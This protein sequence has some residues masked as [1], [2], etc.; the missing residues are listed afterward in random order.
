MRR[1]VLAAVAAALLHAA[2]AGACT[3]PVAGPVLQPF[4]F[5]PAH[6]SA[7]AQPRG[8]DISVAP[9]TPVVAPAAGTVPFAGPVPASGKSVTITT[10]DGLAVT[11]THLG[12]IGVS[13]GAQVREGDPVAASG[14]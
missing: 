2:P 1:V 3:W 8:I 11:L 10:P 5:D 9:G 7:A 14:S 6:P 13:D 12:S 4:S